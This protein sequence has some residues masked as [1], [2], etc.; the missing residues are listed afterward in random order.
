MHDPAPVGRLDR[1]GQ[2]DHEGRGLSGRLGDSAELLGEVAPVDE[3]HREVGQAAGLAHVVDLDDV[4][5][6]EGGEGL[7]LVLE[8]RQLRRPG[9]AAVEHHLERRPDG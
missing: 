4:R 6:L 9:E 5:M 7:G 2:Q 8:P 1:I 3:L